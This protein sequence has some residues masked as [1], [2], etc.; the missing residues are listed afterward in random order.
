MWNH[1][2]FLGYFLYPCQYEPVAIIA[3]VLICGKTD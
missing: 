1:A 3:E 2:V